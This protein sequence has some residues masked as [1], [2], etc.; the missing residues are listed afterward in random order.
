MTLDDNIHSRVDTEVAEGW[1]TACVP[2]TSYKKLEKLK[3]AQ[4]LKSIG[5]AIKFVL[6]N[7]EKTVGVGK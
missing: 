6:D 3:F 1:R 4:G 5:E 2:M 7:F